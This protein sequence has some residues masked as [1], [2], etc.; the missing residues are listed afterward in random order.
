MAPDSQLLCS[1]NELENTTV[2]LSD[3]EGKSLKMVKEINSLG[4]QLQD[5]QVQP[6]GVT[7]SCI[8]G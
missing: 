2:V 6:T 4:S 7:V 5:T 3:I 1:Q 8:M